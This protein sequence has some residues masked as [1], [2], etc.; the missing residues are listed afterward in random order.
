MRRKSIVRNDND[1]ANDSR[2]RDRSN[3]RKGGQR[4]LREHLIKILRYDTRRARCAHHLRGIIISGSPFPTS[5]NGAGFRVPF[6]MSQFVMNLRVV[7]I[8]S[9]FGALVNAETIACC[10]P[11]SRDRVLD[12]CGDSGIRIEL[13]EVFLES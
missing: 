1:L 5:R 6:G 2:M 4:A 12:R 13:N 11:R 7:R 9:S 8:L 10:R 3:T